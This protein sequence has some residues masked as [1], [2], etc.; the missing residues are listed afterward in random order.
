MDKHHPDLIMCRKQPG[1]AIGRLCEKCDGKCVICGA[2]GHI[3]CVL[4][5]RVHST[6][7]RHCRRP[8]QAQLPV[9][10]ILPRHR[11]RRVRIACVLRHARVER[12]QMGVHRALQLHL[13]GLVRV[14]AQ[15]HVLPAD[16]VELRRL[17]LEPCNSQNVPHFVPVQLCIHDREQKKLRS[18]TEQEI[19]NSK[20]SD[21]LKLGIF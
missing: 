11:H 13:V 19:L 12:R 9:Q 14:D 15:H 2:S 18:R 6:G 5:Q 3:L 7:E 1:I 8:L 17:V 10:Q 4:L 16:E 20:N 21:F